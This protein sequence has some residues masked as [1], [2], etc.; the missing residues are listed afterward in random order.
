MSISG[1]QDERAHSG[2]GAHSKPR[3]KVSLVSKEIDEGTGHGVPRYSYEL[4]RGLRRRKIE[5]RTICSE[6]S[7]S[8][9]RNAFDIFIKIPMRVLKPF[10]E[11]DLYHF[12][13]Q[14]MGLVCPLFKK[15]YGKKVVTTVHDIHPLLLPETNRAS[16]L[17]RKAT[18][19]S[20]RHSD[21]LIV[22]A[23]HVKKDLVEYFG[24]DE[25]SIRVIALGV[26]V[27][28][29]PL[30]RPKNKKFTVGY[31]GSFAANKDVAFLIR[32][33][34][35]F[36]RRNPGASKLVLYGDGPQLEQCKRL[37]GELAI[38]DCEFLGF[39]PERDIVGIYN[40]F[41]AYAFPSMM[42]GFGLPLLEAQKC[43]VPVIVR[44]SA[45]L[46]REL[47]RYCLKAEDEHNMASHLEQIFHGG[48]S[49]PKTHRK[50]V[51]AFTWDSCIEKTCRA[52]A[53]LI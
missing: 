27:K 41:D 35:L 10:P 26:D 3:L 25:G 20:V 36:E 38:E 34:S 19:Y 47:T 50:Y 53:E 6:H 44:A 24:A 31:L 16:A 15:L 7:S 30:Q 18:Q 48:F 52:Y 17:Y 22:D 33:Y 5:V 40:S 12:T 32:S 42:E 43:G 51:S 37:A 21:L 14:Q 13:S 29:R 49:Y 8:V 11:S 2:I 45:H 46:P 28:F 4:L 9:L 39:A 23:A 1:K